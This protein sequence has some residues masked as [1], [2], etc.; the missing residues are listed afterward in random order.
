LT[1]RCAVGRV[2]ADHQLTTRSPILT[3]LL[4]ASEHA[5]S[6]PSR[7][8]RL[9][10][11]P[12]TWAKFTKEFVA[13]S[14]ANKALLGTTQ[15]V[16]VVQGGVKVNAL[17]ELVTAQVNYRVDFSESIESTKKHVQ[18]VVG[19]VAKRY[20]QDFHPFDHSNSTKGVSLNVFGIP[21]EPA[22]LTP[23]EGGIWDLFAGTVRWVLVAPS[24]CRLTCRAMNK[25]KHGKP[26][27][28]TPSAST[29]VPSTFQKECCRADDKGQ[30]RLQS[31]LQSD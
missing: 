12:A 4:C 22:P 23:A 9:L 8:A 3:T 17:P 1:K 15:A 24:E 30:H 31:L 25:D 6:F 16:D 14:L 10:R 28:V 27:V 13:E 5:P 21:I 20:G 26:I 19:K 7:W 11:R 2:S 18:K 29:Y